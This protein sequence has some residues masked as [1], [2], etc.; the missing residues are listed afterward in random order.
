ME[1]I[2]LMIVNNLDV[3]CFS[4][5]PEKTDAPLIVNPDAVLPLTP[6]V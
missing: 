3:F 6:A 1:L 5:L 4:I 2:S